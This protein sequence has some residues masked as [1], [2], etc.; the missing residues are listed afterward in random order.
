LPTQYNDGSRVEQEKF[1]LVSEEL[2]EQF[3]A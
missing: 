3:G 1:L 2:T